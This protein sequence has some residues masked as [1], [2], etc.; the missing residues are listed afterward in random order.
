MRWVLIS[1]GLLGLAACGP[2][3][4][5]LMAETTVDELKADLKDPGS[6]QFGETY[7]LIKDGW[8]AICGTYNA[9]NSYG[10]MVGAERF[11]RVFDPADLSALATSDKKSRRLALEY[12]Q[13]T[14]R[15]DQILRETR[16]REPVPTRTRGLFVEASDPLLTVRYTV[17]RC[18]PMH[19]EP[20]RLKP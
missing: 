1:I 14:K 13:Q 6:L 7:V 5:E 8:G 10:G 9:A 12:E 11:V 20:I 16:P 3:T 19:R 18:S 17:D 4:E 2:T 15:V